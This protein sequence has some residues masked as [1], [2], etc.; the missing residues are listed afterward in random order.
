MPSG[1]SPHVAMT[2]YE[3]FGAE[4]CLQPVD[5]TIIDALMAEIGDDVLQF[6]PPEYAGQ[7]QQVF[8]DLHVGELT[9]QNV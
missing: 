1:C 4:N 7:A 8:N 3:E 2:L 5:T 6:V 9:F